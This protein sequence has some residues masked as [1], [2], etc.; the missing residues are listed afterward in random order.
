MCL[1]TLS[2]ITLHYSAL[3]L[4][5][6]T[7]H[8]H[9]T[10]LPCTVITLHCPELSVITMHYYELSLQCTVEHCHYATLSC[11]VKHF[12]Y[13]AEPSNR[14]TE[15]FSYRITHSALNLTA[16]P[17]AALICYQLHCSGF[18]K[19]TVN[20]TYQHCTALL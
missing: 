19:T 7:L 15:I 18:H 11:T 9:Y 16:L 8:C 12:H 5:C 6:T 13:T 20:F 17:Y 4:H 3:S 10:A 2:V 14:V 1:H